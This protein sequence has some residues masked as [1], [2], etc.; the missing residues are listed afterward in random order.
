MLGIPGVI[1]HAHLDAGLM[2]S[3]EQLDQRKMRFEEIRFA[4]ELGI[5]GILRLAERMPGI[6]SASARREFDGIAL[7]EMSAAFGPIR[8]LFDDVFMVQNNRGMARQADRSALRS[9]DVDVEKECV[10]GRHTHGFSI[11]VA[12]RAREV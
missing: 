11:A 6:V 9:F 4:A 10:L 1:A 2:D 3:V 5:A 12:P 8:S 7:T